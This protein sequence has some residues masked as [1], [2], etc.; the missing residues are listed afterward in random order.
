MAGQIRN[1]TTAVA[2]PI[3]FHCSFQ[4]PCYGLISKLTDRAFAV[5]AGTFTL[6]RYSDK[7][8]PDFQRTTAACC[9]T[10]WI[11]DSIVPPHLTAKV[12]LPNPAGEPQEIKIRCHT[13]IWRSV[14]HWATEFSVSNLL[15][16]I[17]KWPSSEKASIH[18]NLGIRSHALSLDF[19]CVSK[20]CT[21]R[22][23]P[24]AT[25]DHRSPQTEPP[26]AK[27]DSHQIQ[28]IMDIE[29][30]D[31]YYW[32][33]ERENQEVI[34]YLNRENDI[35][36]SDARRRQTTGRRTCLRKSRAVSSRMILRSL[37]PIVA[38]FTT[39]DSKKENSIR[40][41]VES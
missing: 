18:V 8:I 11:R 35:H 38:T 3:G 30:I 27:I 22:K 15:Q 5:Y 9:P 12:W 32:L 40:S 6:P 19:G 24:K 36:E 41:I 13:A 17:R 4:I 20:R 39:R 26:V 14:P 25:F 21:N 29:R 28:Q 16:G 23:R 34:D 7:E 37:T 33:R 1:G 2:W 31:D 10:S